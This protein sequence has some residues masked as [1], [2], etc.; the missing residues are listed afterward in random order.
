MKQSPRHDISQWIIVYTIA[1][2]IA[3]EFQDEMP[4]AEELSYRYQ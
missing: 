4:F 3:E 1:T 2:P